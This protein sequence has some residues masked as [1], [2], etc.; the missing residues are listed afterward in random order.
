MATWTDYYFMRQDFMTRTTMK[1]QEDVLV[2]IYK[3]HNIGNL[4]KSYIQ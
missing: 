3:D 2:K 1:N 4:V